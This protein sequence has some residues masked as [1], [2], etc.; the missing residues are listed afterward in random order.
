VDVLVEL[1]EQEREPEQ[2]RRREAEDQ[3]AALVAAHVVG[4]ETILLPLS[5]SAPSI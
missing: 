2:P 1:D 4:L 5:R 3:A